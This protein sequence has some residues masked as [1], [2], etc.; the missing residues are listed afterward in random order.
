MGCFK[1]WCLTNFP[2]MED[3]IKALNNYEIMCK[4]YGYIKHIADDVSKLTTEYTTLMQ[5]FEE[6]K[7]YVNTYLKDL[8]DVKDAINVINQR[9]DE[10]TL[11]TSNNASRIEAVNNNLLSLIASN[12]TILKNYIDTQVTNLNSK[13]DNIQIGQI[14]LYDPTTGTNNS[15]QTIVNN[16]YSIGNVGGI[17][18]GEFDN[19]ELTVTEFETYDMTVFQFDTNSKNILV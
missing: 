3:D 18:V 4:L 12:F 16:L 2:F 15:L 5:S 8:D 9:L 14:S 13:I 6:L 1:T 17:T 19:L 11:E 10:L 7:N